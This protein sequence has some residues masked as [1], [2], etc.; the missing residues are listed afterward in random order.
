MHNKR[1]SSQSMTFKLISNKSIKNQSIS[2][3]NFWKKQWAH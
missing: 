2:I 3:S 1:N